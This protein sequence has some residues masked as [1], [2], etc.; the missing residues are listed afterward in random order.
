MKNL[1]YILFSIL[2]ICLFASCRKNDSPS[3]SGDSS[4]SSSSSSSTPSSEK[5]NV[6]K[7]TSLSSLSDLEAVALYSVNN[8]Y[9]VEIVGTI[10]DSNTTVYK[11][12]R[13]ISISDLNTKK[14][15]SLTYTY[16]LD[17]TFTLSK[18]TSVYTFDSLDVNTLFNVEFVE[19]Y[20]TSK[21]ITLSGLVGEIS[22]ENAKLYFKDDSFKT[23]TNVSVNIAVS[24][25]KLQTVT[26]SYTLDNKAITSTTTYNYLS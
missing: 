9:L 21:T 14:G 13:T 15:S 12:E 6:E 11:V 25:F 16:S 20:F 5:P 1:K 8:T 3:D 19:S 7:P 10:N 26:Y 18:E 4:E 22:K 23:D 2:I 17:Q 24:D